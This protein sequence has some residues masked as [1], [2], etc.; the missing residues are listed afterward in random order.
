MID[1]MT[2]FAA[3]LAAGFFISACKSH[4]NDDMKTSSTAQKAV[5]M[6]KPAAA[7]AT[8]PSNK[9]V[10]G[11]VTFTQADNGVKVAAHLSGLSPGKHGIHIHESADLSDP[12]LKSA[13]SHYNPMHTRHG[14]PDT[15]EHHSG[16]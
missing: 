13:G 8:Q 6:I 15:P 11:E 1:R 2:M 4:D 7:A 9:N 10:T 3:L 14:G 5:A 12:Q 16:D